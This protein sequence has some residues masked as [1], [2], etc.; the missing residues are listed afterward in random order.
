MLN[1]FLLHPVLSVSIR[2]PITVL[3]CQR[4]PIIFRQCHNQTIGRIVKVPVKELPR[5]VSVKGWVKS[6]RK[7]KQN[8]FL[9]LGD[10]VSGAH[11]QVVA[12]TSLLPDN[13]TFHSCVS[14]QGELMESGHPKQ[15]VELMAREVTLINNTGESYPFQPRSFVRPENVRKHPGCKAK[16]NGVSSLLRIRNAASQA[17]HEYFQSEDF[18]QVHTPVLTSND[19]EGGGEVF[20]VTPPSAPPTQGAEEEGAYWDKPV[21]LTVSGQL[22]LEVSSPGM[23]WKWRTA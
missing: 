17:V 1:K 16:T 15:D 23:L 13:L 14:V 18:I 6:L 4:Q 8:T 9:D 3:Q 2:Q 21:H 11:L 22:H 12:D 5:P 10:G 20:T 19:C 7:Q